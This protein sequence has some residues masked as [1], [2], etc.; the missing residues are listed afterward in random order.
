MKTNLKV[1]LATL[2]TVFALSFS[3][4][5]KDPADVDLFVGKYKGFVSYAKGIEIKT[6]PE[7]SVTVTKVGNTYSF[8]FSDAIPNITGVKFEKKDSNT[9]VSIGS[10]LTGITITG[11]KLDMTVMKDGA[12]WK[13]NCTR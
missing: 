12:V 11:D 9:Y 6:N 1:L 4:C 8:F 3:S 5:S 7:G 2:L 13:A 10:G